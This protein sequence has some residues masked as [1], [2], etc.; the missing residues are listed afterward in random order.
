MP[1]VAILIAATPLLAQDVRAPQTLGSLTDNSYSSAVA[2]DGDVSVVVWQNSVTQEIMASYSDGRGVSWSPAKRIDDAPAGTSKWLYDHMIASGNENIYVVWR[3]RRDNGTTEEAYFTATHDGGV[4]WLPNIRLDNGAAVGAEDVDEVEITACGDSVYVLIRAND[5]TA[6]EGEFL[7]SSHDAGLTWSSA[8]RA[9][10]DLG[11]CDDEAIACDGRNVYVAWCDDRNA[12]ADDDMFF[13]MSHDGGQTWMAAEVQ[14][15]ASGPAN[16][17]VDYGIN[18]V[19]VG[20]QLCLTWEEDELPTSAA[21]EEI[22]FRYSDDQGHNWYNEVVI[23]TGFDAD[24]AMLGF[25]GVNILIT[26]EGNQTGVDEAYVSQANVPGI[27]ASWVE[28]Q[29]STALAQ[30]PLVVGDTDYWSILGSGMSFPQTAWAV[31]TRDGGTGGAASWSPEL[32]CHMGAPGDTDFTTGAFNARYG[33]TIVSW[34]SDD[35]GQNTVYVG[36]FRSQSVTAVSPSFTSGDTIH[37]EGT[38]FGVAD[39]TLTGL[40]LATS[41]GTGSFGLPFGDGRNIGLMDVPY[42]PTHLAI[43]SG[44]IGPMG[45]FNTPAVTI[46]TLPPATIMHYCAVALD[47]T[48]GVAFGSLTDVNIMTIN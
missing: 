23:T 29:L 6:G 43:F 32:D 28:T 44:T 18:L 26:Y 13:I 21:D 9:D 42:I 34:L 45:S 39:G 22:H 46:P 7:V 15:D 20:D 33:N 2:T 41:H 35:L 47:R 11:D 30:Y 37:W 48:A 3:D 12:S 16:G 19:C 25:D 10:P 38:G 5:T 27:P 4:T 24:A 8:L 31:T 40:V 17:D 36:G 14:L 1:L